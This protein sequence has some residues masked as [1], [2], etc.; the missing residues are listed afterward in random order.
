MDRVHD[1]ESC[2]I[3][4]IPI[5]SVFARIVQWREHGSSKAMILVRFLT[6][7][8]VVLKTTSNRSDT[9]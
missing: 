6:G 3:G 7:K 1:Y 4:S 5:M 8:G 2:D 9:A